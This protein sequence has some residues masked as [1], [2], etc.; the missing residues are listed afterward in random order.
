MNREEDIRPKRYFTKRKLRAKMIAGMKDR[1][2][3]KRTLP[4]SAHPFDMTS[5][6]PSVLM[7]IY[8]EQRSHI[9]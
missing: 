3:L 2:A 6:D 7:N 1:N 8:V 4:L 5:H 9:S